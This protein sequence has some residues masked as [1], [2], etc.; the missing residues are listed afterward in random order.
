[1]PAG[2]PPRKR[3]PIDAIDIAHRDNPF[4]GGALPE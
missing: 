2:R 1:V 3:A 4:P